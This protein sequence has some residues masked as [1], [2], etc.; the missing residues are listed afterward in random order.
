MS[1]SPFT[2]PVA[3][4][5]FVGGFSVL[6]PSSSETEHYLLLQDTTTGAVTLVVTDE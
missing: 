2:K 4:H 3:N 6:V 5:E 1:L